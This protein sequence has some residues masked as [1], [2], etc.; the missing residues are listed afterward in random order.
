MKK[1]PN[2][3]VLGFL[4]RGGRRKNAGR[5]PKGKV[6]GVS[7][8]RRETL[9][10]RYPV[11][12]TLRVG[13][14]LPRLRTKRVFSVLREALRAGSDRFGFRLCQYSVQTNHLHMIVEAK[15]REALTRGMRG[16]VIRVAKALNRLWQRRGRVFPDRYH[17]RILRTPREVRNALAYVMNNARRHVRNLRY[18]ID[19]FA[20]SL[21]F[22]GWRDREAKHA[23]RDALEWECERPTATARTWL[24]R[25]G[26]RRHGLVSATEVPGESKSAR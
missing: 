3:Q 16:L 21:W 12:V 15:D 17:D 10:S 18:L 8:A 24:L 20:S 22:D 26:W 6:A 2:Q 14:G 19:N 11:H 4:R 1:K 23:V 7:H 13:K 9:A 25:K 5:K